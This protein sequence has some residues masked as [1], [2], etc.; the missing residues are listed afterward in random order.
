MIRCAAPPRYTHTHSCTVAPPQEYYE[1]LESIFVLG[2]GGPTQLDRVITPL[3]D[4]LP[5]QSKRRA[6]KN[7]YERNLKQREK[8]QEAE[9]AAKEAEEAARVK[10]RQKKIEATQLLAAK[11]REEEAKAEK[12]R[13]QAEQAA[14]KKAEREAARK[15]K[16]AAAAV[17][18]E[19]KAERDKAAALAKQA[20]EKEAK[21]AK[22]ERDKAAALAKQA[23]EKEEKAMALAKANTVAS[24][25]SDVADGATERGGWPSWV[26]WAGSTESDDGTGAVEAKAVPEPKLENEPGLLD[27]VKQAAG[28]TA[29]T[30]ASPIKTTA[31]G[32]IEK[33]R[34]LR[35]VVAPKSYD[36]PTGT[37][38]KTKGSAEGSKVKGKKEEDPGGEEAEP[39]FWKRMGGWFGSSTTSKTPPTPQP[40]Q[41]GP[42][43]LVGPRDSRG[44]VAVNRPPRLKKVKVKTTALVVKLRA[45]ERAVFQTRTDEFVD[46]NLGARDFYNAI[47]DLYK[48]SEGSRDTTEALSALNGLLPLLPE[49]KRAALAPV[50]KK[51]R[52][53]G[54][55]FS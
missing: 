22:A 30:V 41:I 25:G 51:L 39:G 16:Q 9:R 8:Q 27:R 12:D 54:G 31:S 38:S 13:L 46:G 35:K 40:P 6:L 55:I 18:K 3:V 15:A 32:T 14:A 10:E 45:K 53:W 36:R 7:V 47:M 23:K 43:P 29:S 48:S 42:R 11:Q 17:E 19:A 20:K 26:P 1:F 33:G 49:E 24:A 2:T 44:R 50:L 52:P 21:K 37:G 28:I 5:D 4:S 34:Q